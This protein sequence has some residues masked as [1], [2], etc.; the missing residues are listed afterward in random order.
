[1]PS[2]SLDVHPFD[3]PWLTARLARHGCHQQVKRIIATP[4]EL[5][6]GGFYYKPVG[7][8]LERPFVGE[9]IQLKP[10]DDLREYLDD[11]FNCVKES[12]EEKYHG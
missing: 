11:W 6:L 3:Q 1:M 7:G 4:Q 10:D 12:K 2:L 8:L 9:A 5:C